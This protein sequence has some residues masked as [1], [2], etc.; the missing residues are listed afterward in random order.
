M[1]ET[2]DQEDITVINIY[3]PNFG[4]TNFIRSILLDF[5]TQINPN[6]GIGD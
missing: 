6:S 3:A 2:T 5:K 4:T 1:K